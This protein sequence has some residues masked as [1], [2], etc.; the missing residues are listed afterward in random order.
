MSNGFEPS[1]AWCVC[2]FKVPLPSVFVEFHVSGP[3][4]FIGGFGLGDPADSGAIVGWM[5][6]Y[7]TGS[8][9]KGGGRC[10]RV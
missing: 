6:Y 3:G 10:G 5:T 8:T 1:D 9:S 2:G 4:D 7:R